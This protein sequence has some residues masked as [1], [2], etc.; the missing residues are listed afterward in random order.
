MTSTVDIL[1]IGAEGI[2]KSALTVAFVQDIFIS[3]HIG[4]SSRLSSH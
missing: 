4:P 1:S 2:G 3:H